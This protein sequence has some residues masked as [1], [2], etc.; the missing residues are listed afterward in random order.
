MEFAREK[1]PWKKSTNYFQTTFILA[2]PSM[3]IVEKQK[4]KHIES[5][6]YIFSG[7]SMRGEREPERVGMG[8]LMVGVVEGAGVSWPTTMYCRFRDTPTTR[9]SN[10]IHTATQSTPTAA[11]GWHLWNYS[12]RA[13]SAS[14]SPAIRH[15]APPKSRRQLRWGQIST[16]LCSCWRGVKECWG[17]ASSE[18]GLIC[19]KCQKILRSC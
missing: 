5:Y 2:R 9:R 1:S 14:V 12:T 18:T 13:I 17:V 4:N 8:N 6:L 16:P 3:L 11:L 7:L 19:S 15:T 10:A